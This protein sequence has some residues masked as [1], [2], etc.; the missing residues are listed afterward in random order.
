MIR[1]FL[2]CELSED[3]RAHISRVQHDLKQRLSREVSKGVRIAW[4]QPSS[5]H[6]TFTFLGDI[7]EQQIDSLRAALS[8][9]F[10][11]TPNFSSRLMTKNFTF[12]TA[13]TS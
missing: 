12:P 3:L 9:S 11:R 5:V 13:R 6:L 10:T 7:D 2:A 1:A 8:L 4:A